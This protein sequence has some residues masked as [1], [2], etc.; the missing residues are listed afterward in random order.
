MHV[1]CIVGSRISD[2]RYGIKFTYMPITDIQGP[3][4]ANT[5]NRCPISVTNSQ[6]T[7]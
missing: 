3:I 4:L 2:A 7:N 1:Y 5:D 6:V